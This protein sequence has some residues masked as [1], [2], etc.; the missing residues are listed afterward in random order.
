MRYNN[1]SYSG[2]MQLIGNAVP[3]LLA[4]VIASRLSE[5]MAD[6]G[7]ATKEGALLSFVPT[8]SSGYS[9]ALKKVAE[10]VCTQFLCCDM[11]IYM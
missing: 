4:S 7:P 6:P 3:P 11:G 2:Q 8:L 9:P 10:K 1:G 5:D